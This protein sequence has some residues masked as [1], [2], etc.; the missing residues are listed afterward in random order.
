MYFYYIRPFDLE[1]F[2]R[3]TSRIFSKGAGKINID[4]LSIMQKKLICHNYY[5]FAFSISNCLFLTPG[6]F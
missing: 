5:V 6:S 3:N 2:K 1:L 4:P